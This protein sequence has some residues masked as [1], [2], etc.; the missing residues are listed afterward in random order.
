MEISDY[1]NAPYQGISQAPPSARLPETA[2]IHQD[3]Y[4]T[5]P[6]GTTKRPPLIWQGQAV[7]TGGLATARFDNVPQGSPQ[8][9]VSLVINQEAGH[10]V[11]RLFRTGTMAVIPVTV[12][13]AAQAYLDANG[14]QPKQDLR[15][16]TVESNT[17]I[18]NRTVKVVNK[19]DTNAPRNPEAIIWVKEGLFGCR[20]SVTVTPNGG[21]P[22]TAGFA[23]A[24][25][26]P[27]NSADSTNIATAL[28]AGTDPDPGHDGVTG[29]PLNTLTSQGFTVTQLGSIIYLS[30]ATDFTIA[31]SDGQ[32]NTV[33]VAIK[34]SVQEFSDLPQVGVQ[35][36][37]VRILQESVGGT[38]DYYVQFQ[39]QQTTTGGV[40]KEC[41]APGAPLGVDTTTLPISIVNNSGTWTC[42]VCPWTRRT[43]GDATLSPDPSFI[44][45]QIKAIKWWKGRL[46]LLA[47]EDLTFSASDN[48]FKFYTT[49][50]ATALDS[51]PIG[52]LTPDATNAF[53]GDA[54]QFD[55]RFVTLGSLS[56]GVVSAL[57]KV[58]TPNTTGMD[59]L[60]N[61]DYTD[62]VPAFGVNHKLYYA[63]LKYSPSG[64]ANTCSI[65]ELQINIWSGL[66]VPQ[67][68]TVGVPSLLPV[69][70]DMATFDQKN[71][72]GMWAASGGP[73]IYL[74]VGME[75][76]QNETPQNSWQVWNLPAGYVMAGMYCKYSTLYVL[77]L[78]PAGALVVLVATMIPDQA[79]EIDGAPVDLRT[80]LDFLVEDTNPVVTVA[81]NA[82]TNQTTY[83]LPIPCN[84]ARGLTCSIRTAGVYPEAYILP[85]ASTTA[86]TVVL[87]G[88]TRGYAINFGYTY[89][90]QM[91]PS[92]FFYRGQDN[93]PVNAARVTLRRLR[94]N[95]GAFGYLRALVNVQG[96][97]Q[98]VTEYQGYQGDNEL[99]PMDAPPQQEDAILT[100]PIGGK[101]NRVSIDFIN[102]TVVGFKLTGYEWEGNLNQRAR[103][104]T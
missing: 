102:D 9:D 62:L 46:A 86:S 58:I 68:M 69:T 14:A 25:A 15:T 26:A 22:V 56:Q 85:V 72:V 37:V 66:A 12:T 89:V 94:A 6:N 2:E 48:P 50:L 101:S 41:L 71:Y 47:P 13:V 57:G 24:L 80:H 103:R 73:S 53:F 75:T 20:F 78:S 33:L 49:T 99:T 63:S 93:R 95:V 70:L 23:T 64:Q 60:S 17:F 27:S 18:L 54:I 21:T 87:P 77:A 36:F 40:W 79:P 29:S 59:P 76:P 16:L 81:Y 3:C 90:S 43:T 32:G 44:G 35:G 38:S 8:T 42:D 39:A 34:T 97:P 51:D 88:D 65:H 45:E 83:T 11:L 61:S 74:R 19:G 84:L 30:C 7:A 82:A 5:I 96:R 31:A 104:I 52:L 100:I 4:T 91:R 10:N 28:Y 92:Q 67:I 55:Q 98:A 1:V